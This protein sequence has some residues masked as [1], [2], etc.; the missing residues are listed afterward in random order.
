MAV[1]NNPMWQAPEVARDPTACSKA[2][3][4]YAFGIVLWELLLMAAPW[5]GVHLA[6]IGNAVQDGERPDVPDDLGCAGREAR[7]ARYAPGELT[8]C[9]AALPARLPV[10]GAHAGA[11][12][13]VGLARGVGAGAR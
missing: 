5:Q 3:D 10:F 6:L 4:V 1:A 2:G 8:A 7:E 11:G 9:A 12:A 13:S